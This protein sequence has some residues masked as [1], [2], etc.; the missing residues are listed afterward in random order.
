MVWSVDPVRMVQ[1]ITARLAHAGVWS[2]NP[3]RSVV[4]WPVFDTRWTSAAVRGRSAD[5]LAAYG[6]LAHT[7]ATGPRR[8]GPRRQPHRID[9]RWLDLAPGRHRAGDLRLGRTVGKEHAKRGGTRQRGDQSDTL[10]AVCCSRPPW[11]LKPGTQ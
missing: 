3:V 1:L 11:R 4:R 9:R 2:V 10:G 6:A 8:M 7:G 5:G